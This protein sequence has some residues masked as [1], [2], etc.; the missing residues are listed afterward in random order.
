MSTATK[1]K[2]IRG[3]D[4]ALAGGLV[5][6]LLGG[7]LAFGGVVWW[8][9]PASALLAASIAAATLAR[10]L[11]VGRWEVMKSPAFAAF[12]L[13]IG[14]GFAQLVPLP[15]GVA[16]LVAPRTAATNALGV[17][18]DRILEDDP[19]FALAEPSPVRSPLSLDRPATLRWVVGALACLATFWV[20][21][22]FAD[23]LQH[24]RVLWGCA[25][26]A[27]FVNVVLAAVQYAGGV[28]GLYGHITPGS[29][30]AWAPTLDDLAAA[31]VPSVLRVVGPTKPDR[32]TLLA[33]RPLAPFQFG[34]LVGG[35]GAFLALASLAIPLA[36]GLALQAL[37]PRGG[38]EGLLLRLRN[39]GHGSQVVLTLALTVAGAVLAGMMAGKTAS[40]PFAAGIAVA[41]VCGTWSAGLRRV[42]WAA[43]LLL[44]LALGGGVAIH[45][46][47]TAEAVPRVSW[48]L[49]AATWR[50]SLAIF[51]D[52]PLLGTGLGAFPTVHPYYKAGDIEPNSAMS[53]LATW[54]VE[55]GVVGLGLLSLVVA[56]AIVRLPGA[57]RRV[58]TAD[59]AL[60]YA[61][62]GSLVAFGLFS[63]IHWT[64]ELPAVALL[65]AAVAG[66]ANR[67][68]AG[69]TDLFVEHA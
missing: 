60:P 38:R 40:A 41:G 32:P 28:G 17:I 14:L 16:R 39:S 19:D 10:A 61:L 25:V 45:D 33:A 62:I 6:L 53:A 3:I 57:I 58:G 68:L 7:A 2:L 43:T 34:S 30:P 26:A 24:V 13:A 66:T 36:L 46:L 59:R 50:E 49:S 52:F 54:A 23:R 27:F 47:T 29:G 12:A 18:P 55:A 63:T 31:P 51:R 37:A 8:M 4:H 48:L 64:V 5:L 44:L 42:G 1:L 11:L 56:W 22:N 9:R 15:A 35:P 21:S 67:W 69:G 20:A 65:A